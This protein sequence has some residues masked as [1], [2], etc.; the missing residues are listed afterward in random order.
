MPAAHL[1][2]V[3][4]NCWTLRP[5]CK[6][7]TAPDHRHLGAATQR[8][9]VMKAPSSTRSVVF[10]SALTQTPYVF[11]RDRREADCARFGVVPT[12]YPPAP[13]QSPPRDRLFALLAAPKPPPRAS[14]SRTEMSASSLSSSA[15]R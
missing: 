4:F 1:H 13:Q 2:R 3:R 15:V 8:D 11:P 10:I 14:M 7:R 12:S 9:P 5:R 6:R